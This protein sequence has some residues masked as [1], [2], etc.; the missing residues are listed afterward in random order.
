MIMKDLSEQM[1]E[2]FKRYIK[3]ECRE[4]FERRERENI[5]ERGKIVN[6]LDVYSADGTELLKRIYQREY[7]VGTNNGSVLWC[8]K[9]GVEN[10]NELLDVD[11]PLI[12]NKNCPICDKHIFREEFEL[13][14][15]CGWQQDS[16][17]EDDYTFSGGANKLCVDDYRKEW[18]IKGKKLF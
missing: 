13:C 3:P 16:V 1:I 10:L 4:N 17:Q 8:A 2:D 14:P 18:V 7:Q 5:K 6:I 15:V 11:F 9:A 12:P